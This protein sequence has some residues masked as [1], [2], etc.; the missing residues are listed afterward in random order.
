MR[1]RIIYDCY[2]GPPVFGIMTA[3]DV[4]TRRIVFNEQLKNLVGFR[5]YN[6]HLEH[7][8]IHFYEVGYF[9]EMLYNGSPEAFTMLNMSEDYV[10]ES[11]H[12][13]RVLKDNKDKLLS[14]AV[15]EVLLKYVKQKKEDMLS[16]TSYFSDEKTVKKL[17]Y[18]K[19]L[20]YI[21][22]LYLRLSKDV[23]IKNK[24]ETER[25]DAKILET[26]KEGR[27][28]KTTIKKEIEQQ[29]EEIEDL[30]SATKIPKRPSKDLLNE[31]LFSIRG[32]EQIEE[33]ERI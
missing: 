10:E 27:F 1:N 29:I 9:A 6:P 18:D 22:N 13:I 3:D 31:L 4:L 24:F 11:S 16:G 32:I 7:G 2:I 23:L 20:A 21:C 25:P 14:M 12:E 19:E 17:G 5:T 15:P 30:M 33:I 26:I 28:S 8:G